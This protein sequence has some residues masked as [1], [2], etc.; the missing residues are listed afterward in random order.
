MYEACDTV[1]TCERVPQQAEEMRSA[2]S[3]TSGHTGA[4]SP[5]HRQVNHVRVYLRG[6]VY[7]S[8]PNVGI[9]AGKES[10]EGTFWAKDTSTGERKMGNPYLEWLPGRVR[11][12]RGVCPPQLQASRHPPE[13]GLPQM[14]FS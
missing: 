7:P 10:K 8:N 4:T 13:C 5:R 6:E 14:R 9:R 2:V 12:P 11:R 1:G 3:I